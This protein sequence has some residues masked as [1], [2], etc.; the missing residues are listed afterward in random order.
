MLVMNGRPW[1]KAA[2]SGKSLFSAVRK[3]G[4]GP[5]VKKAVIT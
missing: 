3:T 1:I 5:K 2:N 4:F